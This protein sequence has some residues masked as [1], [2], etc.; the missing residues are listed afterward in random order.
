MTFRPLGVRIA[1]VAFGVLLF[2]VTAVIWIS[3]PP[4]VRESF[5]PFQRL[6]VLAMGAGVLVIGHALARCRVDADDEGLVVVNGYRSHRLQWAQVLSVRMLPGNPWVTFD[7]A[8]GTTLSA[9]GFQGSDG[10][11]AQRQVRTLR[12]LIDA[13]SAPEPGRS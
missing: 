2:G 10:G 5:T 3:F 9:L 4:H 7:L 8:D 13:H 1:A 6:T 12:R 11:R